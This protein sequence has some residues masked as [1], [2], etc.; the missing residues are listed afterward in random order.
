MKRSIKT[1]L[2]ALVVSLSLAA[3]VLAGTW[4]DG[5][6]AYKRGDYASA[7]RLWRPLAKQGNTGAQFNLGLM[8]Y[9]GQGVKQDYV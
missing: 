9:L 3:P 5:M 1:L 2:A 7:L 6:A 8:Y 4:E